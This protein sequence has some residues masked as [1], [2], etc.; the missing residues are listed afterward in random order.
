ML[1]KIRHYVPQ[2][3]LISIFYSIFSS[4]VTYG[5]QVW[6]QRCTSSVNNIFKLQNRAMRIINFKEFDASVDELYK[7]EILNQ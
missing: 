6:A 5:C 2:K 7:N 1:G 4:H 3:E